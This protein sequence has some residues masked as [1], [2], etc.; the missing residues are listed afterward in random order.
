MSNTWSFVESLL[1][2]GLPLFRGS[3]TGKTAIGELQTFFKN[4][5]T[6]TAHSRHGTLRFSVA[7]LIQLFDDPSLVATDPRISEMR[8]AVY[9]YAQLFQSDES[10]PQVTVL[11][12][13][14]ISILLDGNKTSAAAY[15]H[16]KSSEPE[17]YTLPM[18]CLY[19]PQQRVKHLFV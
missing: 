3:V 18:Y 5:G 9:H 17:N 10:N 13:A 2:A 16:S 15:L 12:A 14:D 7:Q 1:D 8:R 11:A 4:V 19:A 6:A